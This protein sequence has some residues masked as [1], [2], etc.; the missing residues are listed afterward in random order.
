MKKKSVQVTCLCSAYDFPHRIGGGKC[1]G[2]DWAYSYMLLSG[3]ECAVCNCLKGS[4]ECDVVNGVE[5]I[6]HCEGYQDHLHRQPSEQYPVS[7]EEF[8]D[9]IYSDRYMD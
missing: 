6:R 2:S 7:E 1:S 8:F 3:S 5:D 4:G 9:R